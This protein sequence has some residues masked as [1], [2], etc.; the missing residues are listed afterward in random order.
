V[1]Q[2]FL[3]IVKIDWYPVPNRRVNARALFERHY[4][5]TQLCPSQ[6]AAIEA[7]VIQ[8]KNEIAL[9]KEKTLLVQLET[10]RSLMQDQYSQLGH[11]HSLCPRI[12]Q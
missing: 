4:R 11:L 10:L 2:V 9:M 6:T 12:S 5:L 8:I 7:N 1:Y 3:Y